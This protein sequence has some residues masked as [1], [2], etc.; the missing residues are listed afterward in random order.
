[1]Q[2]DQ[3]GTGPFASALE[4][5]RASAGSRNASDGDEPGWA[6]SCTATRPLDFALFPQ[7]M[8]PAFTCGLW[9]QG[10]GLLWLQRR[11]R[12]RGG[13]HGGQAAMGSMPWGQGHRVPPG[14]SRGG[15]RGSK[16]Q[17]EARR[18]LQCSRTRLGGRNEAAS[19][20]TRRTAASNRWLHGG[21]SPFA[22]VAMAA[23]LPR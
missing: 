18:R 11:P 12:G 2:G 1:M 3:S 5:S 20:A 13:S 10:L 16:S 15:H 8:H 7:R 17:E 22:S 19:P 21:A 14:S 4:S 9:S 6:A 23:P